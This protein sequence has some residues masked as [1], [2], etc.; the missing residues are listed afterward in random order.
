MNEIKR[1]TL[2]GYIRLML[3]LLLPFL[4][5]LPAHAQNVSGVSGPVVDGDEHAVEYRFGIVPDGSGSAYSHRFHYEKALS[6]AV[7]ARGVFMARDGVS[8]GLSF[9]SV[10]AELTWQATPDGQQWQ[11]GLRTEIQYTESG[12][13]VF[14]ARWLNE[15]ALG[16][17]WSTRFN[18]I[19]Q[20]ETG[21]NA[22]DGLFVE[23]RSS[24]SREIGE[25]REIGLE[26][27]NDFGSADDMPGFDEQ[28]HQA[29]PYVEFPV[30]EKLSLKAGALFG[31]SRA[32][33]N[34]TFRLSIGRDF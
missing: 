30:G 18:L 6:N 34:T 3:G 15:L 13:V 22:A 21:S 7:K 2:S 14:G 10:R 27:F 28:D 24:I 23:T 25:G 33:D 9:S 26:L 17:V 12:P 5:H 11:S 19:A 1:I 8:E 4:I 31:L 32:A 16:D 29:G 20:T